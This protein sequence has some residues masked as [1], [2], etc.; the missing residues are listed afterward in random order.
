[1]SFPD[2][3][4]IPGGVIHASATGTPSNGN[5]T[6]DI[7]FEPSIALEPDWVEI[8]VIALGGSIRDVTFVS[9]IGTQLTLGFDQIGTDRCYISAL[10]THS[11]V[12]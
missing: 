8:E 11:I 12:R 2:L 4:R 7:G 9:L 10:Y 5:N 6:V 3:V 1:M